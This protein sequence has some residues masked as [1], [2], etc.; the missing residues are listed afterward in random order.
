MGAHELV[1]LGFR[2]DLTTNGI[3]FSACSAHAARQ[4]APPV[5]RIKFEACNP[6]IKVTPSFNECL[7]Q[8][9]RGLDRYP[10]MTLH[11]TRSLL[12]LIRRCTL[13]GDLS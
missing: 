10:S 3:T 11:L 8:A 1:V 5:R 9:E 2:K 7:R 12:W 6:L 13:S 4:N